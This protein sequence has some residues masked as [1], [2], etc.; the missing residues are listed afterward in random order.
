MSVYLLWRK[1]CFE[2][3]TTLPEA[4]RRVKLRL[5]TTSHAAGNPSGARFVV[6]ARPYPSSQPAE[7]H[8][9]RLASAAF[10]WRRRLHCRRAL[11]GS[12]FSRCVLFAS[13]A[14][15]PHLGMDVTTLPPPRDNCFLK[16]RPS[17][18]R[19]TV[20]L[21]LSF[22]QHLL[23]VAHTCLPVLSLGR[24]NYLELLEGATWCC[25]GA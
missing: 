14:R 25:G 12:F 11:R 19:C 16:L 2:L 5:A 20:A 1:I 18:E 6:V 17:P 7:T 21:A 8:R 15:L 23:L 24:E 22:C 9:R 10:L 4:S 3:L 13:G